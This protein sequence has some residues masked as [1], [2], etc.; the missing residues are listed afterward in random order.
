[1]VRGMETLGNN[2]EITHMGGA[3]PDVT[4][5]SV[6]SSIVEVNIPLNFF[7]IFKDSFVGFIIFLNYVFMCSVSVGM[8]CCRMEVRGQSWVSLH[9]PPCWEQSLVATAVQGTWSAA[10][11]GLLESASHGA[12]TRIIDMYVLAVQAYGLQGFELRFPRSHSKRF[13]N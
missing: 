4:S 11:R 7:V 12:N 13:I 9:H 1:M 2:S 3:R 6:N 5:T 10:P 8:P